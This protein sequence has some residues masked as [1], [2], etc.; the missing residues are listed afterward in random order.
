MELSFM[1]YITK[2]QRVIN[3]CETCEQ[4]FMAEKY[5]SL[6]RGRYCKE[7]FSFDSNCVMGPI[8]RGFTEHYNMLVYTKELVDARLKQLSKKEQSKYLTKKQKSIKF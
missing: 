4:L 7:K 3:S 8:V 1:R 5:V 2:T 6:L